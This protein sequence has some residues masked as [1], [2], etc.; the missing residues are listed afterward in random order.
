MG[1]SSLSLEV[2]VEVRGM[3]MTLIVLFALPL[4]LV[5]HVELVVARVLHGA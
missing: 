1:G 5:A 4:I 2:G 3:R